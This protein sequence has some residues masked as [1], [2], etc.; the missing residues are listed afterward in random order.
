MTN[1]I[2]VLTN[3]GLWLV[4]IVLISRPAYGL[5]LRWFVPSRLKALGLSLN[6]LLYSLDRM[7]YLVPLPNYDPRMT[8]AARADMRVEP[9]F[10]GW[11]DPRL[12]GVRV[13][14]RCQTGVERPLAYLA[15]EHFTPPA[16]DRLLLEGRID[17]HL[18]GQISAAKLIQTATMQHMLDEVHAQLQGN[19]YV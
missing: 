6:D 17:Q 16:L 2:I 13:L 18:H 15:A 7:V 10:T 11:V 1:L 5:Y 4:L 9:E 8:G 14:L 19:R 12:K 3:F